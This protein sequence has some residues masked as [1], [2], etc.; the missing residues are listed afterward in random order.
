MLPTLL[1]RCPLC[2]THDALIDKERHFRPDLIHCTACGTHWA[3]I[4]VVGGPDY[5]LRVLNGE[6]AGEERPLAE[7]YD[8]VKADLRLTPV[9]EPAILLEAEELLYLQSGPVELTALSNDPLFWPQVP[10]VQGDQK[11]GPMLDQ[12]GIGELFLTSQRLIFRLGPQ[13]YS[14]WL[15]SLRAVLLQTDRFFILRCEKRRVYLFRFLEESLLKWLAYL[16][17]VIGPVEEAHGLKVHLPYD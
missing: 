2:K 16:R 4:R 8:M 5:R 10:E 17:L 11:G 14:L 12:V 7:W 3:L 9:A 13:A 6:W 15:R 1:W